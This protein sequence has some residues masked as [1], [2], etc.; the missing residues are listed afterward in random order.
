MGHGPGPHV[1]W[2]HV[3]ASSSWHSGPAG[4]ST[5]PGGQEVM[6]KLRQREGKPLLAGT[7]GDWTQHTD[8]HTDLFL[9]GSLDWRKGDPTAVCVF[10]Y[11]R[12]C[13]IGRAH[14]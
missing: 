8:P 12:A 9:L 3:L 10:V 13:E 2:L 5:G 11:V 7:V 4:F 6:G 1:T 14:V